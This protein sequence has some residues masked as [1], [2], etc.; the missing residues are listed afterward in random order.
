M[1]SS[2]EKDNRHL[3]QANLPPTVDSSQRIQ[4]AER[5]L[6]PFFRALKVRA[7]PFLASTS[8]R[9]RATILILLK[10]I[11]WS[12]LFITA[13][14]AMFVVNNPGVAL[15]CASIAATSVLF[16][17]FGVAHDCAHHALTIQRKA[18]DYLFY[19]AMLPLGVDPYLWQLRHLGSHHILPN[20]N[21][22]DADIDDNPFIRLSPHHPRRFYQSAQHIYA[23]ILYCLVLPYTALIED[24]IYL[25]KKKLANMKDIKIPPMHIA[26]FYLF[27]A[28]YLLIW[29]LL[30]L[31]L[32]QHEWYRIILGYFL[33]SGFISLLF[34]Y[35]SA[36]T[37]FSSL[38]TFPHPDSQSKL[39]G[40]WAHHQLA[41]SVDF[42][43]RSKL[44][45]FLSGGF[46]CH[47]AHHLF[48]SVPHPLYAELTPI[49]ASTALEFGVP[50]HSTSLLGM[51]NAHH[52][53][54]KAMSR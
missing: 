21:G 15:I 35:G 9:Q 50:Y 18:Q 10:A 44:A 47:A 51:I 49:I 20:V 8:Q 31:L 27:K 28:L 4:F 54:L 7:M 6:D 45:L 39:P 14:A 2:R 48:P 41:T 11:L 53:H 33:T 22:S 13:Y 24:F 42:S 1:N 12:S 43:T 25:R 19:Y 38:A 46:N 5:N 3:I 17:G 32:L 37:H 29:L 30:P 16:L 40:T 36:G 52:K 23:P 26:R 34:V